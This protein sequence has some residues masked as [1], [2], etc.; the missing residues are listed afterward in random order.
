MRVR[1]CMCAITP[2]SPTGIFAV[3]GLP[4]DRQRRF[5]QAIIMKWQA[6]R[7]RGIETIFAGYN[8]EVAGLLGERHRDDFCRL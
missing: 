3:A 4:G 6:Y 2:F 1:M 7:A 8:Y 5:L